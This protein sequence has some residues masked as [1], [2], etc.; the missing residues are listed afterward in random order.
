MIVSIL[1]SLL[2]NTME[3][4]KVVDKGAEQPFLWKAISCQ[5]ANKGTQHPIH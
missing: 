1:E 4:T 5:Q 3:V 2:G